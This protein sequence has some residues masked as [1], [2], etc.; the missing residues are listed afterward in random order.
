MTSFLIY[1]NFGQRPTLTAVNVD[2]PD[3][4]FLLLFFFIIDLFSSF[5][6]DGSSKTKI[7]TVSASQRP[8]VQ[9]IVN[10]AKSLVG[11]SLSLTLL[12]KSSVVIFLLK[13]C[14]ELLQCKSSYF[15]GKNCSGLT[16]DTF[17]I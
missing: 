14:E 4:L 7:R 8:V 5:S 3:Y 11:D 1:S 13:N 17:E 10:L 12:T 15:F 6:A 16:C 2:W 9:S